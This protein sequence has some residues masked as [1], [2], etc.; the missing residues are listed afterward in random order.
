MKLSNALK[1]FAKVF[2]G[3]SLPILFIALILN[4]FSKKT[5]LKSY[6]YLESEQI[7]SNVKRTISYLNYE[8][9]RISSATVDE[10]SW[11][12]A[13]SFIQSPSDDFISGNT[14]DLNESN[15]NFQLYLATSGENVFSEFLTPE[16]NSSVKFSPEL[17]R[18][19]VANR[20]IW[21]H[22][23]TNDHAAGL[24]IEG[25]RVHLIASRPILTSA[26]EGPVRGTLIFGRTLTDSLLDKWGEELDL[27]ISLTHTEGNERENTSHPQSE[28]IIK[29]L[30]R[31]LIQ[32]S[33]EI[34]T[35]SGSGVVTIA[36]TTPRKII[37]Q[38]ENT[39][40]SFLK[41][42][43][44]SAV[45]LSLAL[46]LII[47]KWR[48]ALQEKKSSQKNYQRLFES[49]N[50]P[51]LEVDFSRVFNALASLRSE[52]VEC[53]ESYL[54][55][56]TDVARWLY[57]NMQIVRGNKVAY[58]FFEVERENENLLTTY[59]VPPMAMSGFLAMLSSFWNK[60]K[61]FCAEFLCTT[62]SEKTFPVI[63]SMPVPNSFENAKNVPITIVDIST[64]KR[65][66]N[67]LLEA[68]AFKSNLLMEVNHR[69]TNNLSAIHS[70]VSKVSYNV[71]HGCSVECGQEFKALEMRIFNLLT[72]HKMLSETQWQPLPAD[73]LIA[74][75]I[76]E[77][78]GGMTIENVILEVTPTDIIC[79]SKYA[80][81][82]A[83]VFGELALNTA[84]YGSGKN[85]NLVVKVAIEK[86]EDL[87][88][89][90]YSDNGPGFPQ[91]VL[92][93]KAEAFGQG[94]K[95]ISGIIKVSMDGSISLFNDVGGNVNI[96]FAMQGQE[97]DKW[98]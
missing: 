41:V 62:S 57:N 89:L 17:Y 23:N 19:I 86:E 1:L 2:W 22:Q 50:V 35:L 9:D 32:G 96:K 77:T 28:S 87:V 90:K 58:D 37:H 98:C 76:S 54:A 95:M 72:V 25:S 59:L 42:V 21:N 93:D 40:H 29:V 53:L 14:V 36:V 39:I 47:S 13:Y 26:G 85:V 5:L 38:G 4:L 30:C 46:S 33:H 51:V 60:E 83:V 88:V 84:K 18:K 75:I 10:A 63:I 94:L 11:D 79:E 70:M 80:H 44:Y 82:L 71:K 61:S 66:E 20:E 45:I 78:L 34:K 24:L 31:E 73:K 3:V 12:E 92:G 16:Q 91:E 49:F 56:N 6:E 65:N 69:V 97:S 67:L 8:I 55:E 81:N 43:N 68:N 74:K 27:K 48:L 64:Q 7:T 15:L 52:G